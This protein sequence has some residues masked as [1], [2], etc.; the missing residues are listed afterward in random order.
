MAT[1]QSI[2]ESHTIGLVLAEKAKRKRLSGTTNAG[3]MKDRMI[4]TDAV[5]AAE[6]IGKALRSVIG[7]LKDTIFDVS[8]EI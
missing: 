8:C 7:C 2:T 4:V 6:T 3:N 5:I 1:S